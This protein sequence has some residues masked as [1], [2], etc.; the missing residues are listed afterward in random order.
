MF[1]CEFCDGG[2][3]LPGDIILSI[4]DL[5]GSLFGLFGHHHD[6]PP[7]HAPPAPQGGYGAGIDPYGTWDES[8]PGGVQVF[9]QVGFPGIHGVSL[10]GSRCD[11]GVCGVN[12]FTG[13]VGVS[14]N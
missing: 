8:I 9:P 6:A 3:N 2:A 13:Q 11:F 5:F 7:P 10:G 12:Q 1:L 14:V 4:I